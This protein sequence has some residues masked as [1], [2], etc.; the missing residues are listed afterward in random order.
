MKKK[1]SSRS[2]ASKA[3]PLFILQAVLILLCWRLFPVLALT[4]LLAPVLLSMVRKDKGFMWLWLV[5]V[6][7]VATAWL[8]PSWG[9][10]VA[11]AAMIP[12][13]LC[14][15]RL[16]GLWA[17]SFKGK[18]RKGS[19]SVGLYALN[20]FALATLVVLKTATACYRYVHGGAIPMLSGMILVAVAVA[21]VLLCVSAFSRRLP[22]DLV[23]GPIRRSLH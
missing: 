7:L 11:L 21:V 9:R 8:L 17:A 12:A 3:T 19:L 1:K 16:L 2:A 18:S 6:A 4:A 23:I 10:Y 20:C 14:G 5:M 22:W 15:A 13:S